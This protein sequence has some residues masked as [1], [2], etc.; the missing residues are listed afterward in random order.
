MQPSR[1]ARHMQCSTVRCITGVNVIAATSVTQS[2]F[3]GSTSR[4]S[5]TFPVPEAPPPALPSGRNPAIS[6][7]EMARCYAGIAE[8]SIGAINQAIHQYA[9]YKS[10]AYRDALNT[11]EFKDG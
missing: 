3:Y 1:M 7:E 5:G 2:G 11:P 6:S 9:Y 8:G 4:V 10:D